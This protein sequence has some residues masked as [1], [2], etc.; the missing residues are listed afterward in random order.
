MVINDRIHILILLL[1][2]FFLFRF[3]IFGLLDFN[4]IIL[5]LQS[6]NFFIIPTNSLLSILHVHVLRLLLLLIL[7]PRRIRFINLLSLRVE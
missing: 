3:L 1:R 4:C 5:R 6:S 7:Y 2:G